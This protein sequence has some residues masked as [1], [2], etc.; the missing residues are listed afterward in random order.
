MKQG[1]CSYEEQETTISMYPKVVGRSEMYSS[2]PP[3]KRRM[4]KWAEQYPE[5]FVIEKEDDV[6]IFV[7]CPRDWFR[8]GPPRRVT[9]SPE[10]KASLAE[11]MRRL[12]SAV[13][14]VEKVEEEV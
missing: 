13:E 7:S 9:L 6:G 14:D 4:M 12:R 1:S 5:E 8:I 2:E 11:R 10:Q 3:V